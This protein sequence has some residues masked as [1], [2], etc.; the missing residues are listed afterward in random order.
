MISIVDVD[1]LMMVVCGEHA[2]WTAGGGSFDVS[3]PQVWIGLRFLAGV[4]MWMD[5]ASV[6]YTDLPLC[7]PL[8]QFC[9]ALSKNNEGSMEPTDCTERKNFLCYK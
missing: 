2:S 7:P 5:R 9:G 4:W 8:G 1:S 6:S 3:S